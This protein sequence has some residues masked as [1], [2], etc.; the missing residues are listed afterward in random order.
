MLKKVDKTVDFTTVSLSPSYISAKDSVSA[1]VGIAIITNT[2]IIT[3]ASSAGKIRRAT[4]I[5]AKQIKGDTISF[6]KHTR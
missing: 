1:A 4:N 3:Y 5:S 2:A 6:R